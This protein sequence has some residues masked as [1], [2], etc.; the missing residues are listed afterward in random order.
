MAPSRAVDVSEIPRR[1]CYP[2]AEVAAILG[3]SRSMVYELIRD[4]QLDAFK[5]GRRTLIP[6]DELTAMMSEPSSSE[7]NTPQVKIPA[8]ELTLDPK[9]FFVYILWS[10]TDTLYV[11]Q[12]SNVLGRVGSH[13]AA[14][15]KSAHVS[16]VDLIRCETRDEMMRVEKV[17]IRR[18][19]PP[20]NTAHVRSLA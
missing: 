10:K 16:R 3:I 13:L 19:A 8:T 12:S 18:H 2:P 5:I 7:P 15:A 17:L 6:A 20:W 14:R 9:G 4:S 1:L 11:G